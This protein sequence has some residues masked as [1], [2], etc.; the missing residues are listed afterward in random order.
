MQAI[1]GC[2]RHGIAGIAPWRDQLAACG[3]PEAARAIRDHGLTVTALCRGGMFT[4]ADAEAR[5]RALDDNRRAIDEALAIGAQCLVLVVGG[6]P[7]G[8][9]DLGEARRQVEDSLGELLVHARAGGMPLALEPLHPMYAADRACVNTLQ[10]ANDLCD[11][12]GAGIGVAV[13]VY[14]VWWD[15]QLA[16]E[17]ARAGKRILGFHICDWLVPT[18]DLLLDR[19]MMGDGVIDIRGIRILVQAAGYAGFCDVEIMS[20]ENW[21]KRDPDEVLRICV[22]RHRTVV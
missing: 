20:A 3:V 11:A 6:L 9:K 18:T 8:S 16:R 19:G 17:I 21:W 4:G 1:E 10:Q 2:A 7:P 5:A 15:P 14:H 22:Q 13:D 12:L